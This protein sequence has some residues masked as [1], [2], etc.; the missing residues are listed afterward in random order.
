MSNFSRTKRRQIVRC[1][2]LL[3][4]SVG[5]A[6]AQKA[7]AKRH[8]APSKSPLAVAQAQ[9]DHG[10]LQAAENTIWPLLNANPNHKE[11]LTLLGVIRG[12]QQ[13]Y[14]EA[15]SLFRRVLKLDPGSPV[16]YRNLGSALV[17]QDKPDEAV[18][19]YKAG[20]KAFPANVD[21]KV[22]LARLYA[23]NGQFADVL[24][25]LNTIPAARVPPEAIPLKAGSLLALGR[26]AEAIKL[27]PQASRSPQATTDL[28]EVFLQA[29]LTDEA[30]KLLNAQ[31]GQSQRLPARFYYVRGKALRVKGQPEAALADFRKALALDPK[32][33]EIL[34]AAAEVLALQNKHADSLNL[35]EQAH[36]LAPS[37]VSVTRPLV[38]EAERAGQHRAALDA[39]HDLVQQSDS[40]KDLYLAAAAMLQ[41]H[42]PA[43]AAAALEKYTAQNADDAK[44]WLGLGMAYLAQQKYPEAGH[45][46][47]RSAQ[48]DPSVADTQYQLGMVAVR[49][50][51]TEDAIQHF[52][53]ALQIQ[54]QPQALAELGTLYLQAGQ[55]D[56]AEDALEKSAAMIP[57][58]SEIEYKLGLVL[59]KLGKTEEARLHMQRAQQ[60]REQSHAQHTPQP[61]EPK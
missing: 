33:S 20:V 56:K 23:G 39:A 37:D 48:L 1:A 19:E 18:Q 38:I 52:E 27:A 15:E 40:A 10:D 57:N 26:Q 60:L 31:N 11:A 21:L 25:T 61:D 36:K 45:A 51:K 49:E 46:L 8:A 32:S 16:A 29:K 34:M 43:G 50:S 12:R 59:G 53:R 9:L 22:D 6:W 2:V 55:L 14:P 47:E 42:D 24:T 13:R 7:P 41:E 54:P 35:L 44:G 17:A 3:L 30:L 5:L 58:N 4:L 28:A